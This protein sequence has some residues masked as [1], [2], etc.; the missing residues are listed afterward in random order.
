M[1]TEDTLLA[2]S[3]WL[4]GQKVVRSEKES[5]DDRTHDK[6]VT[7]FVT[8]W[9]ADDETPCVRRAPLAGAGDMTPL[10][11]RI[12]EIS[13]SKGFTPPNMENLPTKLMLSVSELA[14][15]MEEHRK[16]RGLIWYGEDGKPEGILPELADSI[17]R[18]LHMMHSL[19]LEAGDVFQMTVGD[20]I[21]EK[22]DFN[23][24]RPT[25]HGGNIY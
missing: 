13:T 8:E 15:A 25:M 12:H 9:H 19:I 21:V 3:E 22:V 24:G 5:N 18:N 7:D 2:Y 17:I 16:E 23:E 4:D 20:I 6:L 14:E 11:A 10:A 1:N